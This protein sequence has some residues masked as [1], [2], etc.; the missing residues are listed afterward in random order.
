MA[1]EAPRVIIYQPLCLAVAVGECFKPALPLRSSMT[2][3]ADG[4]VPQP[5]RDC[6]ARAHRTLDAA[7]HPCYG[8]PMTP[9]PPSP[10]LTLPLRLPPV[11]RHKNVPAM[12]PNVTPMSRPC[13]GHGTIG[14]PLPKLKVSKCHTLPREPRC[15]TPPTRQGATQPAGRRSGSKSHLPLSALCGSVIPAPWAPYRPMA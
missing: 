1:P 4:R 9:A 14:R 2:P 10:P 11:P 5:E 12:T 8:S 13:R 6:S 15:S 7:A 3:A